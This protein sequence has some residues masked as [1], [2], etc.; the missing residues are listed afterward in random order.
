MIELI[1]HGWAACLPERRLAFVPAA[2]TFAC[3]LQCCQMCKPGKLQGLP[4]GISLHA[5]AAS[6]TCTAD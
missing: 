1:V 5:V 3:Q 6:H 2:C 4:H